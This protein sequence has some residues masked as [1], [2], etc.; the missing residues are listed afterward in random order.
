MWAERE[1]EGRSWENETR[2]PTGR[3]PQAPSQPPGV[4]EAWCELCE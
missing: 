4:T 2:P 3:L 1:Q